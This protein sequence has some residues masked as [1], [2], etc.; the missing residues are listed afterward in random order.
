MARITLND[1]ALRGSSPSMFHVLRQFLTW[2]GSRKRVDWKDA[3]TAYAIATSLDVGPDATASLTKEQFAFLVVKYV[4]DGLGLKCHGIWAVPVKLELMAI[5][6]KA[7]GD[8]DSDSDS[9]SL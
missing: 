9:D 5:A 3:E 4:T 8:D 7:V 6:V 1:C 2:F